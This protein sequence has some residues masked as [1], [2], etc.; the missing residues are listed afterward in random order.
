M[1]AVVA[2]TRSAYAPYVSE[3]GAEPLPMRDDYAP[4][5]ARGEVWLLEEGE[6]RIPRGLLVLEDRGTYS[7]IYSVAV[8]PE[9]HGRGLGREL[10]SRAEAIARERGH[11]RIELFTN[12]KM[13]KNVS[14]YRHLGYVETGRRPN[15]VQSD[16]VLVDMAK[17]LRRPASADTIRRS[18]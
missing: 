15:P 4:R 11:T 7:L 1:P 17:N 9:R 18:T 13:T 3:L 6:D 12:A 16:W 10:V 2:L 14:I 5:I 8:S